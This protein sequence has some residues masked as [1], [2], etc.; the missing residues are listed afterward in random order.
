DRSRPLLVVIRVV[1]DAQHLSRLVNR[2]AIEELEAWYFGDWEAVRADDDLSWDVK[3]V[4][5]AP[6][7][8]CDNTRMFIA[9]ALSDSQQ[10]SL[11]VESAEHVVI[12]K[13]RWRG[14]NDLSFTLRIT[15]IPDKTA[16]QFRIVV[17]DD[18]V[19]VKPAWDFGCLLFGDCVELFID[20]RPLADQ[21]KPFFTDDVTMLA[22]VP[23]ERDVRMASWTFEE[24]QPT[25][26]PLNDRWDG[27][28]VRSDVTP[29]G[30]YVELTIPLAVFGNL[31]AVGFDVLVDDTDGRRGRS[32]QMVA[33]G[34]ENN[35][36]NPSRFA[37]LLLKPL[38]PTPQW[39][40]TV[41]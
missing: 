31:P 22:L 38:R 12:G 17:R 11:R 29:N 14:A 25:L 26:I 4:T 34:W 40:V 28:Q 9:G 10:D 13:Q 39:R 32:K 15:R 36:R 41:H 16:L 3:W 19:V 24:V 8:W 7:I 23:G 21:G 30:Y 18:V 20:H 5:W 33:F 6:V 37:T 27:V 2:I 35:F 1:L